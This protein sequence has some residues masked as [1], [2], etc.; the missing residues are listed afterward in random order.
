MDQHIKSRRHM[1]RALR[2]EVLGP[3]SKGRILKSDHSLNFDSD[4]EF[5]GPHIQEGSLNEIVKGE[6]PKRRFGAGILFP[7]GEP[8]RPEIE[9][10][11]GVVTREGEPPPEAE[12]VPISE[13]AKKK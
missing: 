1:I 8:P 7:A 9:D 13:A 6:S 11:E 12:A 4:D 2:E 5:Y 10:R 3:I